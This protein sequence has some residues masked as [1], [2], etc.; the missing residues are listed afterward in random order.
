MCVCVC[1]HC[2]NIIMVG[3]LFINEL[4][5]YLHHL[6]NFN[7]IDELHVYELKSSFGY[8]FIHEKSKL[9]AAEFLLGEQ[10]ELHTGVFN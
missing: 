6:T 4:I 3:C 8:I 1:V 7:W 5:V 9:I 2:S 10:S